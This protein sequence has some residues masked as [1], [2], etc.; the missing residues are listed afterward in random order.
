M[1]A[2]LAAL[3]SLGHAG[4]SR[5][6]R[7]GGRF[8]HGGALSVPQPCG[9]LSRPGSRAPAS[10]ASP[11]ALGLAVSST[12]LPEPFRVRNPFCS[13]VPDPAAPLGPVARSGVDAKAP[14]ISRSRGLSVSADAGNEPVASAHAESSAQQK[15][16]PGQASGVF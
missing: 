5:V 3:L 15:T 12:R 1:T 16:P 7:Y 8:G 11:P 14:A 10:D 13:R 6:A 9:G 2:L 4:L